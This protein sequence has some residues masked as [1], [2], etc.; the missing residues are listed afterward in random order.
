MR[1]F[2]SVSASVSYT[3]MLMFLPRLLLLLLPNADIKGTRKNTSTCV[4]GVDWNRYSTQK[5]T[6][7]PTRLNRTSEHLPRSACSL[8]LS[9]STSAS[10]GLER[11]RCDSG[12]QFVRRMMPS[13]NMD[14]H[15][16][17]P[18]L[19]AYYRP[20]CTEL[21]PIFTCPS[22]PS[23]RQSSLSRSF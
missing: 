5:V 4:L 2:L 14:A 3:V 12:G 21:C 18:V 16:Q 1:I 7:V 19:L 9:F 23:A 11:H 13:E 20:L 15:F 17:P 8:S 6:F 22:S 10:S